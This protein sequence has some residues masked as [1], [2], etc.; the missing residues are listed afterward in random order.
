MFVRRSPT[1]RQPT[2]T[3]N[4]KS[5]TK[6]VLATVTAAGVLT[7]GGAS[8]AYAADGSAGTTGGGGAAATARAQHPEAV[9]AAIKAAFLAAA[10]TLGMTPKELRDAVKTGPQSI[11]G[12]AGGQTGAV[13]DSVTAALNSTLDEAVANGRFP[14]ERA[15]EV[16]ARI[17]QVA[18]R[19]VNRVPGT[20]AR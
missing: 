18:E 8:V 14:A 15:E 16:R 6:K 20:R 1:E 19:F 3:M 13:I 2:M 10:D 5:T 11:A 17:P 7:L 9:R 4:V 12:V